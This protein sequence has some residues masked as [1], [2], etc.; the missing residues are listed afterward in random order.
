MKKAVKIAAAAAAVCIAGAVCWCL[1]TPDPQKLH[2]SPVEVDYIYDTSSRE[3]TAG[4]SDYVFVGSG[5]LRTGYSYTADQAG[6]P[7]TVYTVDVVQNIKGTL[8]TDTPVT[9]KAAGGVN[10]TKT[11]LV[12]VN[13][14][15]FIPEEGKKYIFAAGVDRDGT[16]VVRSGGTVPCDTDGVIEIYR[17]AVRNEVQNEIV[18][19]TWNDRNHVYGQTQEISG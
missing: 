8:P 15:Y 18:R 14:E 7:Y 5:V 10:R 16:L 3:E 13:D 12:V 4:M 9:V 6:L 17:E 2:V 19:K 11:A 1:Y